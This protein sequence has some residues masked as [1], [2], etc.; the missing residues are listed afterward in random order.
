MG[1][2]NFKTF[3]VMLFLFTVLSECL[4]IKFLTGFWKGKFN[5]NNISILFN[6]LLFIKPY[7]VGDNII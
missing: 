4:I 2:F 6:F 1:L 7:N 3:N 5:F